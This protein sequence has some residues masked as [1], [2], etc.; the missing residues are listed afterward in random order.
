[1]MA[2]SMAYVAN[3]RNHPL[4]WP[5]GISFTAHLLLL[6]LII[7]SPDWKSE[8]T[9]IPMVVDVQ[10]V[11]LQDLAAPPAQK[12]A[13]S[14]EQA[15]V[16]EEQAKET[17]EVSVQKAES[18]QTPEISVAPPRKKT[19]KAL[20]YKTFKSK[21]VIKNALKRVEKRMDTQ[22][23]KPLEDTIKRL[24]EKVA[25]EGKPAPGVEGAKQ[26]GVAGKTG[27]Y[28]RGSKKEGELIDLY[29]LEIAYA[30]N[31]N[32]A[33]AKQL[34]GGRDEL[35]ARVVFKVMPDG[36]IVDITFMDRSGNQYLDDSAYKAIVKSSPVRPHPEKLSI[37]YVLMGLKFTPEGV[38]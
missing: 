4:F 20:K 24:R 3:G 34:A 11:D 32:W 21:K 13:P 15:P 28:G 8:P 17:A 25:K 12:Q 14:K 36:S 7:F 33:F 23:P 19:K 18:K 1:M 5:F 38:K 16:V 27:V 37:P 35:T 10:M 31:K 2:P 6:G 30:V 22:P 26:S 9:F 29:Q